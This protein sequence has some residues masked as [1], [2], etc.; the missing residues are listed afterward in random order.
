MNHAGAVSRR[1]AFSMEINIQHLA[2]AT[3]EISFWYSDC[4]SYR[5]E[6]DLTD[7]I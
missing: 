1:P 5:I 2:L 7:L 4:L 6:I 3:A